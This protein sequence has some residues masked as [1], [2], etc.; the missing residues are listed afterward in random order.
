MDRRKFLASSGAA[1]T[2]AVC[3]THV[4]A[5]SLQGLLQ[6]SSDVLGRTGDGREVALTAGA[7]KELSEVLRGPLLLSGSEAYESARHVLNASIDK[8]PALIVQ[9]TGV[10]DIGTAIQFAKD[11]DLLVAVK[12]GG[13]S[14]SGKSTCDKGML[15]DL[16]LHRDVRV[17]PKNRIAH[18]TGGSHLGPI[19]HE[20]A[21]HGLVTTAGTV[22]HTGVGGLTTGG[23]YGRVARRYGLA[24]DNVLAVDVVSA[25]G[26]LRHAD[27]NENAD[28]YWGVRGA[29]GNFGIVTSFQFQLHEMNRQV[30]GGD[31]VFPFKHAR[32]VLNLYAE[33]AETVSDEMYIDIVIRKAAEGKPGFA[34]MHACYSGD[35]KKA[36]DLVKPI[37]GIGRPLVDQIKWRDYVE[38]QRSWDDTDPRA[39][40]TYLKAGLIPQLSGE[41]INAILDGLEED[42]R[43]DTS[44][45]FQHAGGA[46]AEIAEDATAL[47]NRSPIANMLATTSWK[48]GGD[49]A[50]HRA[51]IKEYWAKLEPFTE[52]F[53]INEVDDQSSRTVSQNFGANYQ[54]LVKIK[55]RYDPT[56]LFRLNANVV[57]TA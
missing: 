35:P 13:H 30:Y 6:V 25:D 57:P 53:Y 3:S 50:P 33:M 16:S 43:R 19:D 45:Y 23:G 9:P 46:I 36:E 24:L 26:K 47:S 18:V 1:L 52:G 39:K 20:C 21:A 44:V 14:F 40:A 28:L 8:H 49:M 55:N 31:I 41:L 51:Y 2:S 22:S 29:G 37:R 56:N 34:F 38:I 54:R 12:C 7:I 10:A 15:I 48:A 4:S 27:N 5:A 42:V 17:D 11:Y 32:D